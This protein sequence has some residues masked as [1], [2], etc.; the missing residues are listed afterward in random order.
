MTQFTNQGKNSKPK[1]SKEHTEYGIMNI[2]L[3]TAC[4]MIKSTFVRPISKCH[5]SRSLPSYPNQLQGRLAALLVLCIC[6][7][8]YVTEYKCMYMY[9]AVLLPQVYTIRIVYNG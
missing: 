8:N 4:E 5:I 2:L 9:T 3:V 1:T 6:L 7:C